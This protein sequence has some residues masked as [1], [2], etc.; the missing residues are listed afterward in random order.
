[1]KMYLT[2]IITTLSLLT[3][4]LAYANTTEGPVTSGSIVSSQ[5][6]DGKTHL[7]LKIEMPVCHA[8]LK[9]EANVFTYY[10]N[11]KAFIT[12]SAEA[13]FENKDIL[14]VTDGSKV[15]EVELDRKVELEDIYLGFEK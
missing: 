2:T 5:L 1:M 15:I 14:C 10:E 3:A 7:K 8:Q 11:E 4:G 12:V 9:G 13:E 6:K